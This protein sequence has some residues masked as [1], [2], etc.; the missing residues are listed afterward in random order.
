M[1]EKYCVFYGPRTGALFATVA[2]V[3][4]VS[5][6]AWNGACHLA[7]KEQPAAGGYVCVS[8]GDGD[9]AKYPLFAWAG[10]E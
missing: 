1:K 7:V 6:F 10:L 8:D 5:C 9:G 2:P 4:S 3:I